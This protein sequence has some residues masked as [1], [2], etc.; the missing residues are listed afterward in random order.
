MATVT[1]VLPA[2]TELLARRD[3]SFALSKR[4]GGH[5][6]VAV[7]ADETIVLHL[8]GAVATIDASGGAGRST[9]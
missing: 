6:Q 2:T 8:P 4:W 1:P 7:D 5:A 9:P 3:G